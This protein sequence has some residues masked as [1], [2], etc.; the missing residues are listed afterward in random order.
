MLSDV[1]ILMH[2]SSVLHLSLSPDI[3]LV[4][5][6]KTKDKQRVPVVTLLDLGFVGHP[7]DIRTADEII[8]LCSP[9]YIAPEL[10]QQNGGN[11][12]KRTDL[13]GLGLIMH[14][15]FSGSSVFNFR[16]RSDAEIKRDIFRN[17]PANLVR[18]DLADELVT[19]VNRST[20]P[21]TSRIEHPENIVDALKKFFGTVPIE[22]P[23]R[24]TNWPFILIVLAAV[25]A[26][27]SC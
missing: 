10:L 7:K 4:R 22:K 11:I 19:M 1:L 3:I 23:K 20:R 24:K 16:L 14:E 8:K 27:Y 13:Y 21:Y 2:E 26:I 9:A 25:T 5:Y 18:N 12:G 15:M 6:G 17:P